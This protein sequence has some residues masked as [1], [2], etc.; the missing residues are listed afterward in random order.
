MEWLIPGGLLNLVALTIFY[1]NIPKL[2]LFFYVMGLLICLSMQWICMYLIRRGKPQDVFYACLFMIALGFLMYKLPDF[3][4][5]SLFIF[6]S[7]LMGINWLFYNLI[8]QPSISGQKKRDDLEGLK[9]F[10]K[11]AEK[12]RL[13]MLNP[14][15]LTPHFF[16]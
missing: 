6:T 12:H 3:P 9:M 7:I 11:V 1:I 15:D 16:E 14:P 10:M 8:K 4:K 5:M 13:N 2:H